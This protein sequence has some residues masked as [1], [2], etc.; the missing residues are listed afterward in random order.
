MFLSQTDGVRFGPTQNITNTYVVYASRDPLRWPRDT[1]CPQK[2]ALTSLT[3][4]G[5]SVIIVRS[6]TKAK[7]LLLLLL[8]LFL[9]VV[10][11]VVVV[12]VILHILF[13]IS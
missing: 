9:I 10:V 12:V 7:E 4:G 2:S 6:R 5:R 11:V 13:Y 1:L 3:S 8:L